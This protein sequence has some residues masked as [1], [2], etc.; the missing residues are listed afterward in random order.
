MPRMKTST[1][2]L[3]GLSA[4]AAV[5]CGDDDSTSGD[6]S[7]PT[8]TVGSGG[9]GGST[10]SSSTGGGGGAATCTSYCATIM[11][12][13]TGANAQYASEADCASV[14]ALW[15]HGADMAANTVE[16]HAYH[17]DASMSAPDMH[18]VHAGPWGD[19]QCGDPCDNFCELVAQACPMA[20]ADDT[21]CD[22]A[23]NGYTEGDYGITATGD[24]L[25]CR[26]Y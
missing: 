15:T 1:I 8:T 19:G 23:C 22:A 25:A 17:A 24:T 12:A 10:T 9:S 6:T 13:C 21:T 5:A 11:D 3:L 18:C 16:C 7:N 14:C 20:Y 26:M 2:M 4:F